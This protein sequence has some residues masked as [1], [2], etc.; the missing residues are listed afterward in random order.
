MCVYVLICV[1]LLVT[2]WDLLKI[3]VYG[4]R[5]FTKWF[6]KS[7]PTYFI[8]PLRLSGSA[9]ESLFSQYKHN[10]GGKLDSVNYSTA[11]AAHL[12]KQTVTTHHSGKGYRD[13]N[14]NTMELPLRKKTYNKH[15]NTNT[16]S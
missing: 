11:R 14:L 7:Y 16:S 6:F 12:V 8:V 10:A 1:M 13:E 5:A 9:I 2:A 3:D 15:S 4:F